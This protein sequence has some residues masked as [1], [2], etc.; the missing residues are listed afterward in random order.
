MWAKLLFK[1]VRIKVFVHRDE[2]PQWV[3]HFKGIKFLLAYDTQR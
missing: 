1:F 3:I 2:R